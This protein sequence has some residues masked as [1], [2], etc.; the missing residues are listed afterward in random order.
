LVHI[1]LISEGQFWLGGLVSISL[2]VLIIF[3]CKFSLSFASLYPIEETSSSEKMSVNCDGM[4]FNAKFTS[5]LQLLST[6]KLKEQA[7][8]A[9]LDEQEIILTIHLVSTG[10]SCRNLSIQQNRRHGLSIPTTSFQCYE[11]NSILNISVVL[12]QKIGTTQ[13]DLVGPHFV[14]A[15]RLCFTSP[16]II[17]DNGIYTA[18][19]MDFCQLFFTPNETLTSSP[20]INVKMTKAVNRTASMT[21]S[22]MVTYTGLWLPTLTMNT[23]HDHLLFSQKG[24]SY[25]YLPTRMSLIVDITESEFYIQNTQE[26][27]ARTYE[28]AFNTILFASKRLV[29][30]HSKLV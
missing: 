12:P 24:D 20:T 30:F 25:R 16:S 17:F 15:L 26:P 18:Q 29:L 28:I 4:L 1:D 6:R 22:D 19:K 23:L 9:L 10:F 11:N 21:L 8:F 2:F 5:S 14:G 7:M 3:A 27:I 13:F